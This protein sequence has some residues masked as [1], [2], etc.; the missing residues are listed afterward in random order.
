MKKIVFISLFSILTLATQA[1]KGD[2]QTLVVKTQI[3]CSHCMQCGSCGANIND[4]IREANKG[5]KKVSIDPK[6]NTISITYDSAK[7]SPEK[8][9][10]A[11][12]ASGYDADENKATKETVAKL[13]GCCKKH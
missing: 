6:E 10:A 4:H 11:I 3:Y 9:K 12:L 8:I 7:T 2:Y 1:H 13:D 5:I